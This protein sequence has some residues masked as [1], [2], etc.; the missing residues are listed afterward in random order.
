[1][2]SFVAGL[3]AASAGHAW[4]AEGTSEEGRDAKHGGLVERPAMRLLQVLRE[5]H[6]CFEV[7]ARFRV[8]PELRCCRHKRDDP[9]FRFDAG[10]SVVPGRR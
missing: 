8:G 4:P 6:L 2:L 9:S 3:L 1:M 5:R 10:W 7:A